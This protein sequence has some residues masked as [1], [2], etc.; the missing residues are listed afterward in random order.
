MNS[1][2]ANKFNVESFY[3]LHLFFYENFISWFI[4]R[5]F[6][7]KTYNNIILRLCK[8]KKISIRTNEMPR[9]PPPGGI[10]NFIYHARYHLKPSR[11]IGRGIKYVIQER[12][13]EV[14]VVYM[15][16]SFS[17]FRIF[18]INSSCPQNDFKLFYICKSLHDIS[19]RSVFQIGKLKN[20]LLRIKCI[21]SHFVAKQWDTFSWS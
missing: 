7:R 13:S 18:W 19:P 10:K 1:I 4:S 11:Q 5:N 20:F 3:N 6:M 16:Y 14:V 17:N 21:R 15:F 9:P 2:T 8:I 12:W